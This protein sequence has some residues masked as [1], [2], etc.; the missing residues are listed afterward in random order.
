MGKDCANLAWKFG[1]EAGSGINE[2]MQFLAGR[3]LTEMASTEKYCHDGECV[4]PSSNV[5]HTDLGFLNGS[6]VSVT[7]GTDLHVLLPLPVS[8]GEE[9]H[10]DAVGPLS[11]ELQGLGRVAKV[12]TVHHVLE[13]LEKN[14]RMGHM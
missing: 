2:E 14:H 3:I 4:V 1:T 12:S 11:V 9:L 7:H 5:Q 8:L 10:H 6:I 13:N